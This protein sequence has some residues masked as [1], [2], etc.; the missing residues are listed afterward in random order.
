MPAVKNSDGSV[1]INGLRLS[2]AE[3][4]DIASAKPVFR[5]LTI[6]TR[7]GKSYGNDGTPRFGIGYDAETESWTYLDENFEPIP[8]TSWKAKNLS[9][10]TFTFHMPS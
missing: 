10:A 8:G 3:V 9:R 6:V 7:S 4:A 1:S 2:A 5:P